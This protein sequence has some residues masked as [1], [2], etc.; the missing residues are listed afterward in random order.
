MTRR[1]R[2]HL[3]PSWDPPTLRANLEEQ[4]Y[5]TEL[6]ADIICA[7]PIV[8]FIVDGRFV[9]Q[10]IDPWKEAPELMQQLRQLKNAQVAEQERLHQQSERERYS[11]DQG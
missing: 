7:R 3:G 1:E 2:D 10:E 8:G 11:H 5:I 4:S 6:V 9:R